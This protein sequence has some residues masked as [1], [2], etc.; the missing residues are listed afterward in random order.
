MIEFLSK[1]DKRVY[2]LIRNRLIHGLESPKLREINEILGRSSPRSAV[3]ALMRL[4]E[5]G[6]IRRMEGNKIHLT[7]ISLQS[8]LSISTVKVPLVGSIAAGNPILAEQDI[9]AYIPI[10]FAIAKP[11]NKYFLLRVV[12]DSMNE[13]I[14]K[15]EKIEEGCLLL[16]QQQSTAENGQIIV[17]L[18]NE[19]ATVKVFE[20][21]NQFVFLKPRSTNPIHKPIVL[22]ENCLIQGVIVAVLPAD[23]Y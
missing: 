12:G 8:D 5:A 4:E 23:L 2:S 3:L 18:I 16:V 6:L 9:T 14:V 19:E 20:R 1:N 11:G 10:T 13:A 22:S 15:G 7:T 17:A 21:K